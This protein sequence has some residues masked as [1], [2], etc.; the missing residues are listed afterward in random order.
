MEEKKNPRYIR[1]KYSEGQ[2][3]ATAKYNAKTYD[4]ISVR[5]SKGRKTELQTH[6]DEQGESLN[7]FIN[8]AINEAI[9][10]DN[11]K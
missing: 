11:K 6:A 3:E 4:Q 2:K 7:G 5:I 10:R 1:G 8:R 9:E